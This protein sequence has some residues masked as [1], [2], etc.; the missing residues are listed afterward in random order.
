[1]IDVYGINHALGTNLKSGF[2]KKLSNINRDINEFYTRDDFFTQEDLNI[3]MIYLHR[4]QI[5]GG[6]ININNIKEL[7]E[8]CLILSSKFNKDVSLIERGVF[9]DKIIETLNW[10]LF[11]TPEDYNKYELLFRSLFN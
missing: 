10:N 3:A 9:E 6:V 8:T 7:I 1:M 2:F 4:Y 5:S 11:V